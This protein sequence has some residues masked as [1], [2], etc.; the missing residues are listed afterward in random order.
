MAADADNQ[1]IIDVI[2]SI[3]TGSVSSYGRIAERAGL[4]R[5]A[6]LVGRILR[7]APEQ[8]NL[9]WYRVLR[10]NGQIAF[11]ASS[12]AF[13]RQVDLLAGEGVSVVAGRVD[14]DRYGWDQNIDRLLWGPGG[15]Q[16]ASD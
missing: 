10:A 4:S 11:P 12:R 3:P 6:R 5:R 7:D 2:L 16:G 13:E 9:P 1:A 15:E 8:L 14:M